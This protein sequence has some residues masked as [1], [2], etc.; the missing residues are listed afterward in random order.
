MATQTAEYVADVVIRRDA[1]FICAVPFAEDAFDN[2]EP[3]VKEIVDSDGEAV[4]IG[5][6]QVVKVGSLR[7]WSVKVG[8]C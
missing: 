4:L 6:C 1:L 3:D 7:R 5:A 8:P 2:R